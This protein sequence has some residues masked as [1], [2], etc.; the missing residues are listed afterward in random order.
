[1]FSKEQQQRKY[2]TKNLL[3]TS[4]KLISK[5]DN[6]KNICDMFTRKLLIQQLINE[7]ILNAIFATRFLVSN[8]KMANIKDQLLATISMLLAIDVNPSLK[9]LDTIVFTRKKRSFTKAF[10]SKSLKRSKLDFAIV[11]SIASSKS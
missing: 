10:S 9:T 3:L 8:A 4:R 11:A 6:R 1:M 5:F 2:S 7:E